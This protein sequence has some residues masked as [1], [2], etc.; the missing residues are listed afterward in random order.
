[1]SLAITGVPLPMA[2]SSV[3]GSPSRAEGW[4]KVR[5]LV[6]SSSSSSP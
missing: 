3:S 6:K 5:A 4:T 2:S 1:M